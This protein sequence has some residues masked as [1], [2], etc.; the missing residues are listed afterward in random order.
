[1]LR[2]SGIADAKKI[3]ELAHRFLAIDQSAEKQQAVA[4]GQC[5]LQGAR[6]VCGGAHGLRVDLSGKIL[7]Y[8][9][10]HIFEYMSYRIFV[11]LR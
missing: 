9:Y 1:M 10:I 7:V 2:G 6:L 5:F 4:V 11:K 8:S 3:G